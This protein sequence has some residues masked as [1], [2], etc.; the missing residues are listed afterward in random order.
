MIGLDT[1]VLVRY[2]AQD[3]AHQSPLAS[4]IFS[5]L[6]IENPGFV[7]S[8]ALVELVWVMQSCYGSSKAEIVKI[9]QMLCGTR[10]L[11]V[12]NADATVA[13]VEIFAASSADFAD[14]L[15]EQAGQSA[16]CQYTVTFDRTAAKLSGMHLLE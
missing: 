12:E 15:I 5:K 9:L 6:S 16:G 13:A 14:C 7:T 8:V 4:K 3:E 2:F 1:N 10:E 11:S